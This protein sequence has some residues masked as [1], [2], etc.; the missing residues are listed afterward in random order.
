MVFSIFP[1][2]FLSMT[3]LYFRNRRNCRNDCHVNK[4]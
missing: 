4:R 3:K 2:V 1:E